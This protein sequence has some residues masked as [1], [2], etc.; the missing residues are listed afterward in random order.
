MRHCFIIY[1]FVLGGF[2]ACNQPSQKEISKPSRDFQA[3]EYY[4]Y[5]QIKDSAFYYYNR[6]ITFSKDSLEKGTAYFKMGL[7]QLEVGDY[8]SAQES[9]LASIRT[10]DEKDATHHNY[11]SA[12]YNTLANATLALKDYESAIR[13]YD[14]ASKF[15]S[16]GDSKLYIAN[17]LGV[18][19][20]K[21]KDYQKSIA[22]F[23]SAI[24]QPTQDTSLKSKLIS[25]TA[26]TRWLADSNFNALPDFILALN[27]R[28]AIKD[29]GGMNASYAHLVDYYL[30]T[31]PDSALYYAIERYKIAQNLGDPGN[32][33]E[34]LSQLAKASPPRETKLYLDQYLKLDDSLNTSRS[35]DR[36]QYVLI[37]FDA[38]KS[39]ADNLVLQKHIGRQRLM[40]WGTAVVALLFIL[41][42]IYRARVK[43][44]RLKLESENAIRESRLKTSQKVH[45]VVANGLYRI[46]NEL[47]HRELIDRAPLLN[48]IEGLYEKSRDISYE[49]EIPDNEEHDQQIHDLIT[50]Y[51][52][53]QTKII[54]IGNQ[55]SFWG[56]ISP[57]QKHE[58]QMILEELLVN[59]QKHS[60]ASKVI[61]RFQQEAG[62]GYITYKDDGQGFPIPHTYGNGLKN[63]VN[64]IKSISGAINFDKNQESGVCISITFPLR[65]NNDDRQSPDSRRP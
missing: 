45:D 61:F 2:W 47:E 21:K 31:N 9:L 58:L 32:R 35:R 44:N 22:V 1:L 52:S 29:S 20:Q 40:I 43:R 25:N 63:T 11:L 59:M 14:L 3:A 33:L 6:V 27:L 50:S 42:L 28:Q 8:Y 34:A 46:M 12:G 56:N 38:E 36:N 41:A 15:A 7:R 24:N 18:A 55:K 4:D 13:N 10:L 16:V 49:K 37:K 23:N 17:N 62:S 51:S 60:R 64:R 48:Q 57:A 19:Y 65:D 5:Y 53:D 54:I 26:R 30:N 39:K